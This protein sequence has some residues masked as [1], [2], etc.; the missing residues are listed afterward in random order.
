MNPEELTAYK[1]ERSKI[2]YQNNTDVI[3]KKL[4]EKVEC[5]ICGRKVIHQFMPK[6]VRAKIQVQGRMAVPP[7]AYALT[8]RT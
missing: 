7:C 6:H 4:M 3:N 8:R 2:Y 1:R 5:P